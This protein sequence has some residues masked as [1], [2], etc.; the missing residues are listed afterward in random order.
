MKKRKTIILTAGIIFL[1][2]P[3]WNI[4]SPCD[5]ALTE[6]H[7]YW[8]HAKWGL[9]NNAFLCRLYYSDVHQTMIHNRVNGR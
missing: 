5:A 4:G 3:Q 8:K 1:L 2:L 9:C 7:A 6:T